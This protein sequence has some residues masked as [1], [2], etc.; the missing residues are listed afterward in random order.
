[1]SNQS[2]NQNIKYCEFEFIK[3]FN[4]VNVLILCILYD[5]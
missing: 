1:M 4:R 2:E 3:R 5:I